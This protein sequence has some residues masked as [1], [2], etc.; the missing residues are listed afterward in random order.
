MQIVEFNKRM[1]GPLGLI[2]LRLVL[3]I[4]STGYGIIL[5]ISTLIANNSKSLEVLIGQFSFVIAMSAI[6]EIIMI[7]S[8]VYMLQWK[9]QFI[10]SYVAFA[11]LNIVL[12]IINRDFQ[13]AFVFCGME[14]LI[15]L[16]LFTSKKVAEN[17]KFYNKVNTTAIKANKIKEYNKRFADRKKV[18]DELERITKLYRNSM[19][20]EDEFMDQRANLID[21]L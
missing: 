6:V 2:L 12:C 11:A 1:R 13:S 15:I 17:Y 7:V 21:R 8:L 9:K 20:R 16:Y 18:G 14:A 5:L 10:Y 19:I 4:L 3:G